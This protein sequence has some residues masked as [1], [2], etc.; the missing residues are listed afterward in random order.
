MNGGASQLLLRVS[1]L[2][3][4]LPLH[5]CHRIQFFSGAVHPSAARG[6]LARVLRTHLGHRGRSSPTGGWRP[7]PTGGRQ[8]RRA[9]STGT[10]G[11]P[12]SSATESSGR[13]LSKAQTRQGSS[14]LLRSHLRARLALG[15]HSRLTIS[16]VDHHPERRPHD[17]ANVA[18]DVERADQVGVLPRMESERGT[19]TRV[20]TRTQA[21]HVLNV[22]W[23]HSQY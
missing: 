10:G 5:P 12:P 22:H 7:S 13:Y 17:D 16:E 15:S 11:T 4:A 14:Q 21:A 1:I 23:E 6:I 18:E 2:T 3:A 8:R 20:S 19:G 9:R